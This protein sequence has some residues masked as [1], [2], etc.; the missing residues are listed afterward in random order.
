MRQL[1]LSEGPEQVLANHFTELTRHPR[2]HTHIARI[3]PPELQHHLHRPLL[4]LKRVPLLG[5][6]VLRHA[7][8][9]SKVKSLH[10]TQSES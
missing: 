10:Q 3:L 4:Q 8:S 7:P 6:V 1:E 5:C 2:D 9:S